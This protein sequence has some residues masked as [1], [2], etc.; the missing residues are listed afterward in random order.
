MLGDVAASHAVP[1]QDAKPQTESCPLGLRLETVDRQLA[2]LLKRRVPRELAALHGNPRQLQDASQRSEGQGALRHVRAP[3]QNEQLR[4]RVACLGALCSVVM[5]PLRHTDLPLLLLCAG[6]RLRG[7]KTDPAIEVEAQQVNDLPGRL[8]RQAGILH[9]G[10]EV[11]LAHRHRPLQLLKLMPIQAAA[12]QRP[13]RLHRI[14][15]ARRRHGKLCPILTRDV[16][17]ERKPHGADTRRGTIGFT[18]LQLRLRRRSR[19]SS[20]P[21][22]LDLNTALLQLLLPAALQKLAG[23]LAELSKHLLLPLVDL[24]R[25]CG[26]QR[27]AVLLVDLIRLGPGPVARPGLQLLGSALAHLQL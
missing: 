22:A 2:C 10:I 12:R 23:I 4:Q 6:C 24:L 26:I 3:R 17:V 14:H 7:P 21:V 8:R 1:E 9:D 15:P 13:Q 11:G 18:F 20:P 27:L 19:R 25:R 5:Q 16:R